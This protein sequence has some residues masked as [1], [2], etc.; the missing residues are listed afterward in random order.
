MY[1]RHSFRDN[2][3]PWYPAGYYLKDKSV[4]PPPPPFKTAVKNFLYDFPCDVI[5]IPLHARTNVDAITSGYRWAD[6]ARWYLHIMCVHVDLIVSTIIFFSISQHNFFLVFSPQSISESFRATYLPHL[7]ITNML[8][9]AQRRTGYVS[10]HSIISLGDGQ[11][12]ILSLRLALWCWSW[13][14]RELHT[15]MLHT[16]VSFEKRKYRSSGQKQFRV[17]V[18]LY[19][20]QSYRNPK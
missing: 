5:G 16:S 13:L 10:F 9:N 19:L 2:R 15:R 14:C 3:D 18:E 12:G 20:P 11:N 17:H 1:T 8:I 7:P 4:S 6:V